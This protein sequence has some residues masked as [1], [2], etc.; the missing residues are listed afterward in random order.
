MYKLNDLIDLYAQYHEI[1]YKTAKD[2]YICVE[3]GTSCLSM[4][5]EY[6][7]PESSPK[8]RLLPFMTGEEVI[9]ELNK[10]VPGL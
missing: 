10:T 5:N 9:G 7:F 3:P 2:M 8:N 6:R 1:G 4:F